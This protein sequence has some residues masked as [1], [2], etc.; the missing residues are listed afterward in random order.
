MEAE[1]RLTQK[2]KK[3]SWKILAKTNVHIVTKKGTGRKIAWT[4]SRKRRWTWL[5]TMM[6]PMKPRSSPYPLVTMMN[7]SSTLTVLTT[8]AT[9]PNGDLFLVFKETDG[10]VANMDNN[11]TCKTEGIGAIRLKIFDSATWNLLMLGMFKTRRII[12][13]LWEPWTVVSVTLNVAQW[14]IGDN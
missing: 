7:R 1:E 11:N 3:K 9:C 5:I 2:V 12:W 10:G 6:M 13:F 4:R 8:R 14:S